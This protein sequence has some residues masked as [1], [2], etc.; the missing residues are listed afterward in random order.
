MAPGGAPR[1]Q[2]EPLWLHGEPPWLQGES[3]WL[4]GE[5]PWLQGEPPEGQDDPP[6]L[7]DELHGSGEYLS[8]L[9]EGMPKRLQMVIEKDGGGKAKC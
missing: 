2:D 4:Q 8:N 7:Q 1:L 6:W 5:P 9:V 3:R